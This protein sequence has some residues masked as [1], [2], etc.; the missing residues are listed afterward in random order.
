MINVIKWKDVLEFLKKHW[1]EILVCLIMLIAG[2]F[3]GRKTIKVVKP[4]VTVEYVQGTPIHDTTTITKP[5]YVKAPVD[6]AN[7]IA[8]C[9]KDGIYSELFPE[10]VKY[11][12]VFM[13]KSDTTKIMADWATER[14][15]N[16]KLFAVDTL[17]KCEVNAVIQYNRLK[18][19]D[20]TYT[21]VQKVVTKTVYQVKM[22]S[23]FLKA[24]VA[25]NPWSKQQADILG[26]LGAGLYIKER[27]GFELEYQR[28]FKTNEDYLGTSILFKF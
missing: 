2:F 16:Q 27:Y 7:L 18:S 12:T 8:Q 1:I 15:Y 11:D 17:G 6:T 22:V 24:G 19:M 4:G 21:P 14:K 13:S 10:R 3:L 28:G 26:K 25:F 20:Y 5:V 9:V 23:P